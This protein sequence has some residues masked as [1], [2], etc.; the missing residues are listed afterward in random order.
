MAERIFEQA[1]AF[2]LSQEGGYE[3]D[4]RDPGGETNWGIDKRSHPEVDIKNLTRDG[5]IEIYRREYWSKSRCPDLPQPLAA[6]HFDC[7]VNQGGDF[8]ARTLQE[9]LGVVVDGKVGGKTLA[10][11]A[12]LDDQGL[13][14]TVAEYALRRA[15][16]YVL[17]SKFSIYGRGWLHRLMRVVILAARLPP[18]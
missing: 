3:N 17:N 8:A 12:A 10:A 6:L 15:L 1:V 9:A 14:A 2:V 11:A 4:P 7:S 13:L 16:R 18:R 5:A